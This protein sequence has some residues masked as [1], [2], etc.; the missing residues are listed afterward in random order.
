[1]S[2]AD[3]NQRAASTGRP[4]DE[5]NHHRRRAA[6]AADAGSRMF[7]QGTC[8][9]VVDPTSGRR[10]VASPWPPG[11]GTAHHAVGDRLG[12]GRH[13]AERKSARRS[14]AGPPAITSPALSATAAAS[15]TRKE[16]WFA[17]L[18]TE[19]QNTLRGH[20]PWLDASFQGGH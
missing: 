20:D 4:G 19:G 2:G 7:G 5:A 10:C 14:S 17:G 15:R 9:E 16:Q 3:Q 8:F 1:M 13:C 12:G 6:N 18:R 11:P